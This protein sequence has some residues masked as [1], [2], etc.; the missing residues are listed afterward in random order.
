MKPGTK[1]INGHI[2]TEHD[3]KLYNDMN[4]WIN[5]YKEA[6][7]DIVRGSL[8]EREMDFRLDQRNRLYKMI[9]GL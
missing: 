6:H 5:K 8:V 2:V 4:E 3:A 7:P 1:L 9:A